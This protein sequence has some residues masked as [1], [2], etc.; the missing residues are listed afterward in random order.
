MVRRSI[1]AWFAFLAVPAIASGA[2]RAQDSNARTQQGTTGQRQ[3]NTGGN[4]PPP[5]QAGTVKSKSNITN[6]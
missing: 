4:S 3:Q 5:A 2:A 6:N 1:L